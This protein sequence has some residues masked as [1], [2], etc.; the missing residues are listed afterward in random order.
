MRN[1]SPIVK[2]LLRL[3]LLAIVFMLALSAAALA[4]QAYKTTARVNLRESPSLSAVILRTLNAGVTVQVEEYDADG[5]SK[6]TTVSGLIG[7]IKSEYLKEDKPAA[8]TETSSDAGQTAA[9]QTT[10]YRTNANV[11]FRKSP[12][13]QGEVIKLLS[14]GTAV[15]VVEYK[16]G[17]WSVA[18]WNG[19]TGYIKSEYLTE[20]SAYESAGDVE[21]LVWSE[22]KKILPT[23]TP[24]KITDVRT[25]SVYNI[26]CF[27]KGSHADVETLTKQDTDILHKTFSNRWQWTVR[28]V[29]VTFNGRTVA[30]S[31]NGKPHGGSTIKDNG[32]NGQVCL[33]FKDSKVH[34]GN[35]RFEKEHQ[36]GV[37]EAWNAAKR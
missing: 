8:K 14:A 22:V 23:Y 19:T 6:V 32:M 37:M 11:N 10:A 28:P 15:E 2:K 1:S 3:L 34:N 35:K 7:Y 4:A 20:A 24:L 12:S 31:I 18:V 9:G 33:H 17:D 26:Q 16:P 30:A 21:L 13:L 27:S 29:W 5:W 25:G 36:D